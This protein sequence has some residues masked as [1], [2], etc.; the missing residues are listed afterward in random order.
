[1]VDWCGDVFGPRV[2]TRPQQAPCSGQIQAVEV[3]LIGAEQ[4]SC[5]QA[6]LSLGP[7]RGQWADQNC[8]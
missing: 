3:A 2:D 5:L 1:M 7:V 8:V 6:E 4:W